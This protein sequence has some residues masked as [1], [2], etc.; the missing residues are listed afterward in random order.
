MESS[1]KVVYCLLHNF[2]SGLGKFLKMFCRIRR[3]SEVF[4]EF[5]KG[6]KFLTDLV[7]VMEMSSEVF[8]MFWRGIND[9]HVL[10]V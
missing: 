3:A 2:L 1:W 10:A 6:G 9:D 7:E 4:W 8:G 5:W